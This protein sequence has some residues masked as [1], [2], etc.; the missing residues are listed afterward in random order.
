MQREY[1]LPRESTEVG[2]VPGSATLA[3][4]SSLSCEPHGL[5]WAARSDS[6]NSPLLR[7][8]LQSL[9]A[10]PLSRSALCESENSVAVAGTRT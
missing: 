7:F 4:A 2:A 8:S 3:C 9:F 6:S 1:C 10:C 5:R